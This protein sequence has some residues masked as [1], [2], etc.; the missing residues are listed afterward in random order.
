[1]SHRT[2]AR[3]LDG[4]RGA[5]LGTF[6]G[7]ALG[8]PWADLPASLTPDVVEMTDG[9]L[10]RGSYTDDT[11][12]TIAVAESLL[13]RGEVVEEHLA[14]R[15][16]E[17]V[18]PIRGYG[19]STTAVFDQLSRGIPVA[20]AARQV[21]DKQGSAGNGAAMRVAP[22]AIRFA[23]RA[24]ALIEN[25]RRSAR[26]THVHPVGVDAAVV[27]AAAIAAALTGANVQAAALARASTPQIREALRTA[28]AFGARD[29]GPAE[30]AA[31]TPR[32]PAAPAALCRAIWCATAHDDFEAVVSAAVR[33]GGDTDTTAAMAGAIA[34]ARFGALAIPTRW[35]DQLVD[36]DRGRTYVERLAEQLHWQA[37]AARREGH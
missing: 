32:S 30:V 13:A 9:R 25:A 12:M 14:D 21:R 5:L 15:L 2:S 22:I 35:L 3:R 8:M 33:C 27:Q 1:L 7:D 34:G 19:A 11:E 17:R 10:P 36:G 23:H 31:A 37:L 24:P 28:A 26:V 29:A 4:A 20:V 18:T 6:V 16:L